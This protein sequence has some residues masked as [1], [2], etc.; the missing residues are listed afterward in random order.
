VYDRNGFVVFSTK[1]IGERWDGRHKGV[2]VASSV[3]VWILEY[4][5]VDGK[6]VFEKGTVTL[7]R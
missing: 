5:S 7:I 1:T 2:K 3:F 4:E 6:P